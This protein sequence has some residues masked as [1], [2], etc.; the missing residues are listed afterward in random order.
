MPE[1]MDGVQTRWPRSLLL[2][3]EVE[4]RQNLEGKRAGPKTLSALI[5]L[6]A[7]QYLAEVRRKR[8]YSAAVKAK[9]RRHGQAQ[10]LPTE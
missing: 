3:L 5:R 2:E 10:S 8:E 6:A 1:P 7:Q 4:V 9:R